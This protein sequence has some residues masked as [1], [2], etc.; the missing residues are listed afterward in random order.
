MIKRLICKLNIEGDDARCIRGDMLQGVLMEHINAD[1]ARELHLQGL[2]PYSQYLNLDRDGAYW[3][4]QTLTQQAGQEIIEPLSS[5]DFTE[6]HLERLNK[7]VL[8]S[9]KKQSFMLM[10]D[11]V[12]RFYFDKGER[13]LSICFL[14]ST[15]FKSGG[16][17]VFY[18]NPR[19]LFG[20]LMRKYST[21]CE[22]ITEEDSD[23]L[24][25]VV[26]NTKIISYNL[27]SVYSEIGR[28]RLPAFRGTVTLKLSG[29]DSLINYIN[30]LLRFGEYSG[31]GIKCSMGMG[32]IR[33]L[34]KRERGVYKT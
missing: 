21:I 14:T 33:I 16:E 31:V 20:S 15:S 17:Y 10:K 13:V 26:E 1:Y 6:F 19:L 28:I 12:N 3:V 11:M 30:F 22:G 32:A 2:N 34:E 9:E 23:T 24:D 7:Q 18:P 8:I 29:A 25:S 4:I 5:P 27:R